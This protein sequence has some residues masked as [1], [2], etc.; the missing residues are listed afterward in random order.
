VLKLLRRY[1]ALLKAGKVFSTLQMAMPFT[2]FLSMM[3]I[4]LLRKLT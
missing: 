4:A 2:H 3:P 1:G